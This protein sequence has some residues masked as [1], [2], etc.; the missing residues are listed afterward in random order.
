[1]YRNG[2]VPA[3]DRPRLI[4]S[5]LWLGSLVFFG[6]GDLLT[7]SIGLVAVGVVEINPVGASLDRQFGFVAMIALKVGILGACYGL[8]QVSP[9]P[10]RAGIPL[11][12]ATV[13]VLVTAWNLHVLTVALLW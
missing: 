2:R 11:G 3:F 9:R 4:S 5:Q 1:M 7:T 6:L 8:W 12:L 10:H 13:G